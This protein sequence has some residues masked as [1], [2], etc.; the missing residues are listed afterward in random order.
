M[1]L[2]YVSESGM[3]V[4]T[5]CPI[6]S[7]GRYS[8]WLNRLFTPAGRLTRCSWISSSKVLA[9]GFWAAREMLARIPATPANA[10]LGS[11]GMT[12]LLGRWR[13]GCLIRR[14]CYRTSGPLGLVTARRLSP[15]RWLRLEN[16]IGPAAEPS[17]A[18]KLLF[19][20]AGSVSVLLPTCFKREV[21]LHLLIAIPV[22]TSA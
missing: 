10:G 14:D 16:A 19:C 3:S 13:P 17:P 15:R 8:A 2:T 4:Q 22:A 12:V 21:R 20:C 18:L 9:P 7:V 6:A 1:S 11:R 5:S